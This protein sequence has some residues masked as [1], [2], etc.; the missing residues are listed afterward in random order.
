MF[1]GY[2]LAKVGAITMST[3]SRGPGGTM[4]IRADAP[5]GPLVAG[6][7]MPDTKPP[8]SLQRIYTTITAPLVSKPTGSH[9][10]Y[11]VTK[12]TDPAAH[13]ASDPFPEIFFNT[14]TLVEYPEVSLTLN[15]ATGDA[16][17]GWYTTPVKFTLAST[18]FSAATRQYRLDGGAWT[19]Y[20]AEVTVSAPGA[21]T[22]EYRGTNAAGTTEVSSVA[23]T[24][25][26]VTD[27]PGTVGGSVPATLSLALGAPATFGA[28]TPGVAKDY[29]AATTAN[30][31]ST[32]DDA[33]LTVSEPG[34]L[35][36]GAFSLP[37]PLQVSLSKAAWTAPT[38][39][40][41]VTISFKQP[42][43]ANDALRTGAY[44][45]TLTFTLSTTSP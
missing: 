17:N 33:A 23:F 11:F 43:K 36:N 12:W 44:S 28:F 39:N 26:S 45:K 20:T 13:G 9:D 18:G 4:E 35:T 14:Y 42:I 8:A 10:L 40:E 2:N 32:A 19:D 5:T 34:H 1:E 30:V 3:S 21:H 22:L 37:E 7:V 25:G 24:I 15:P 27:T 31:V 29:T 41:P 16:S 6:A 38:S